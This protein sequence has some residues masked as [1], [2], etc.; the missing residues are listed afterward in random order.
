[1]SERK[2][3]DL[4]NANFI[5]EKMSYADAVKDISPIQ[6]PEDVIL[7]EKKISAKII[8]KDYDNKCAKLEI[9]SS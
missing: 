6:W 3:L 7:G 5:K 8:E 9:S 2:T 4:S 1:M